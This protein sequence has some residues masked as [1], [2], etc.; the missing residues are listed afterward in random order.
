MQG[1]AFREPSG[2][3]QDFLALPRSR[4]ARLS[5]GDV[6]QVVVNQARETVVCGFDAGNPT[7]F[8]NR[9]ILG[10]RSHTVSRGRGALVRAYEE[11]S[12]ALRRLQLVR[13]GKS[14]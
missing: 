14:A 12:A 8:G 9:P 1:N 2:P 6:T 11:Y 5:E 13:L 7:P 10:S 4:V 3:A